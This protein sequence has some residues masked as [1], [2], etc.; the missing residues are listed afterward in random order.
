MKC[1][2]AAKSVVRLALTWTLIA[3]IPACQAESTVSLDKHARKIHH[4]LAKYDP[5]TYVDLE[6]RDG[7][8]SAGDL[9][10]L[11]AGSF[12]ITNEE[13][14]LPETHSYGDVVKVWR[15]K[16][17]IG[18]GSESGH[19]IRLWI[20]VVASVLAGGAAAAALTVR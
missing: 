7:S 2:F 12:T 13:N 4:Q 9:S 3:A 17:Y 18:K 8:S 19:R 10:A 6:F 5:G 16:E 14:N 11:A 15:G 1:T 20:P